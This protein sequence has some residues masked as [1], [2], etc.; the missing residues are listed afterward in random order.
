MCIQGL[1]ISLF[2]FNSEKIDLAINAGYPPEKLKM[3]LT[4]CFILSLILFKFVIFKG[5]LEV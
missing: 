2:G 5:L 1:S 3:N 4:S